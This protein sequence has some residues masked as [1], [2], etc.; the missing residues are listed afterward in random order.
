MR[1]RAHGLA[2]CV[3][4]RRALTCALRA[5][6]YSHVV[7]RGVTCCPLHVVAFIVVACVHV[8]ALLCEFSLCHVVSHVVSVSSR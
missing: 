8:R 1:A 4:P 5:A 3:G 7:V 2:S 6:V